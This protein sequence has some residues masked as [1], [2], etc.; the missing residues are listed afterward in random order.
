M[1]LSASK[2]TTTNIDALYLKPMKSYIPSV[3]EIEVPY[4]FNY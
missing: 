1:P 2:I 4:E 3:E